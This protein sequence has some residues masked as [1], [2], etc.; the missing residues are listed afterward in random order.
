VLLLLI[1]LFIILLLLN[2]LLTSVAK[3]NDAM[4][5]LLD[6]CRTWQP[7]GYKCNVGT[8]RCV[9]RAVE[10]VLVWFWSLFVLARRCVLSCILDDVTETM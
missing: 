9:C 2:F 4:N 6:C 3:N 5:W 1:L 7:V 8:S 10:S